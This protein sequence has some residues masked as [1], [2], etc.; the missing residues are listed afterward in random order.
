MEVK[1]ARTNY[2][3]AIERWQNQKKNVELA[4]KIFETTQ[5]KYREGVG[6]SIEINQAEQSLFDSQSNYIRSRY[7]LLVAKKD[8][9]QAL[10]K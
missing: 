9:D 7:D 5:I 4:E 10:G 3:S 8:M 6:S 1:N 2:D